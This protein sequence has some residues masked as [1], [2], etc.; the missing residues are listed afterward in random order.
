MEK[1]TTERWCKSK[2][3]RANTN[4]RNICKFTVSE[5]MYDLTD[6]LT[7]KLHIDAEE[8]SDEDCIDND[9]PEFCT[10]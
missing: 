3:H 7:H 6:P 2:L 10:S 8:E 9:L 1:E 4:I 5:L